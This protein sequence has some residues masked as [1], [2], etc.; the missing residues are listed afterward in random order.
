MTPIQF[1]LA[2]GAAQIALLSGAH[3]TGRLAAAKNCAEEKAASAGQAID[4]QNADNDL[5]RDAGAHSDEELLRQITRLRAQLEDNY[6]P[7]NLDCD[8]PGSGD[9]VW[10]AHDEIFETRLPAGSGGD[11]A[12]G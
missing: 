12:S 4:E 2:L 9:S 5:Q 3:W 6:V 7:L 8:A 10:D 11:G 1:Y